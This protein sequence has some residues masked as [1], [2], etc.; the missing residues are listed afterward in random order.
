M[1]YLTFKRTKFLLLGVKFHLNKM[2]KLKNARL[3]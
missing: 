3:F 2:I 1:L